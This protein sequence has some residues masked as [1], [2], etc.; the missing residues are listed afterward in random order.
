MLH[1]DDAGMVSAVDLNKGRLRIFEETAKLQNVDD[2]V[3][4]VHA[5]LR[6]FSSSNRHSQ[7][8]HFIFPYFPSDLPSLAAIPSSLPPIP[9]PTNPRNVPLPSLVFDAGSNLLSLSLSPNRQTPKSFPLSAYLDR[10]SSPGSSY[11]QHNTLFVLRHDTVS[12]FDRVLAPSKLN[13]DVYE[14]RGADPS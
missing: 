2:I 13:L 7:A 5:D 8:P 3:T 12:G 6:N 10:I 4:A 1:G 14:S 11:L 9:S